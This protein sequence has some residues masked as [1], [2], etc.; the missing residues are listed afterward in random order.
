MN[1]ET[2]SLFH[3]SQATNND[4]NVM[5]MGGGKGGKAENKDCS[6]NYNCGRVHAIRHGSRKE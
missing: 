6:V 1:F 4:G 5:Y 2:L 3:K